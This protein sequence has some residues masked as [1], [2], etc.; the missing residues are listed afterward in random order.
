ML[1][2]D[3]T[4]FRDFW[5]ESKVLAY[6]AN[7]LQ[8][9]ALRLTLYDSKIAFVNTKEFRCVDVLLR[10]IDINLKPEEDLVIACVTVENECSSQ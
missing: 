3:Q 6:T 10:L 4:T 5:Q 8:K 1:C 2:T 9:F 7:K